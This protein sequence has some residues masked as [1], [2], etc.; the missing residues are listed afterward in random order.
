MSIDVNRFRQHRPVDVQEMVAKAHSVRANQEHYLAQ[1]E[2]QVDPNQPH[3]MDVRKARRPLLPSSSIKPGTLRPKQATTVFM[4]PN[5]QVAAK[6]R[7]RTNGVPPSDFMT[8]HYS[9]AQTTGPV[10]SIDTSS[11]ADPATEGRSKHTAMW[12][13]GVL[14]FVGVGVAVAYHMSK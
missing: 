12:V 2:G 6:S 5:D 7:L 10:S 13:I 14:V 3:L 1:G 8:R 9:Y 4:H 11:S